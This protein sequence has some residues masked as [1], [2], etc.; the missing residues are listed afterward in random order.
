[1]GFEAERL[2]ILVGGAADVDRDAAGTVVGVLLDPPVGTH[3]LGHG[4]HPH[5]HLFVAID[6]RSI[7]DGGQGSVKR[8]TNMP[9]PAHLLAGRHSCTLLLVWVV[10]MVAPPIGDHCGDGGNCL[11][12]VLLSHGDHVG[13]QY[14]D[15]CRPFSPAFRRLTALGGLGAFSY[16]RLP[17]A[18]RC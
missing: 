8:F 2:V 14:L 5:D 11:L 18:E 16:R 13:R 6:R 9:M 12:F 10:L 1:M 17:A 7:C 4:Y 15:L 3:F